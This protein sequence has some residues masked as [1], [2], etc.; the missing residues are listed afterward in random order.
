MLA[1]G[2]PAPS[3]AARNQDGREVRLADYLGR[4]S[5]V[6][7]FYSLDNTPG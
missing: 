5:V 7:Y 6:L 1:E 3:F 4:N 2:I